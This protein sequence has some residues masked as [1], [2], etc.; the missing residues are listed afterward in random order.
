MYLRCS[1][2]PV[3]LV[4]FSLR[5]FLGRA[6]DQNGEIISSFPHGAFEVHDNTSAGYLLTIP[7]PP[8]FELNDSF[9]LNVQ[10]VKA[11]KQNLATVL[12]QLNVSEDIVSIKVEEGAPLINSTIIE[13]FT[14][15]N[16]NRSMALRPRQNDNG[17]NDF[18]EGLGGAASDIGC[19]AFAGGGVPGF[20]AAAAIFE[21]QNSRSQGITTDQDYFVHA[22]YGDTASS[23]SIRVFYNARYAP[24]F[25]NNIHA[26]T[27]SRR[28]YTRFPP[29]VFGDS[30][31]ETMTSLL[32]HEIQHV[33]Q[34]ASFN[35]DLNSFGYQYLFQ[36]CKAGFN[37]N[38]PRFT[39]EED[40]RR[41]EWFSHPADI[42]LLPE[43]SSDITHQPPRPALLRS[44]E[45]E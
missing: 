33:K 5:S 32:T 19:A 21:G 14:Q 37:Y 7:L 13:L 38:D 20:L 39:L 8:P 35:H 44:L 42:I 6:Q 2:S 18:F 43:F 4:L 10:S 29:A 23:A 12:P 1:Q 25:D 11:I 24:G 28:I 31:F 45:K 27:F 17:I 26:V 22:L 36:Y 41:Q 30:R 9:Q 16:T 15:D 3:L 40:A 34:Y